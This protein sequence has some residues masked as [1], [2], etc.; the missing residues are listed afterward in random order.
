ML[1]GHQFPGTF[2]TDKLAVF[3]PLIGHLS[4]PVCASIL[5][6]SYSCPSTANDR[7]IGM[8]IAISIKKAG[9]LGDICGFKA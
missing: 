9:F 3:G 4:D 5:L 2:L 6:D 8:K 1:Q 7:G